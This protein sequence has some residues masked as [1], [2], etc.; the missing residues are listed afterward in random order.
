MKGESGTP[1]SSG[2][3]NLT[4]VKHFKPNLSG[5][6]PTLSIFTGVNPLLSNCILKTVHI[7]NN[8]NI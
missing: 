6:N 1:W 3:G 4:G 8:A 2:S 7:V 5:V